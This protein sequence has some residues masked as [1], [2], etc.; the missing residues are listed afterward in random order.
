MENSLIKKE[1]K[2]NSLK[3]DLILALHDIGAV[4]FGSFKLKS[5]LTSPFYI[6]LRSVISYPKIM[7]MIVRLLSEA[8]EDL[9]FDLVTGIPYTAL[10][11][12]SVLSAKSNVPLIYQRK[13]PKVYGTGK[14]IE[15][16]YKDG[17]VCLVID[18]VMSTG[19]SKL[20]IANALLSA[21]IKIKD[22][23]IIVDRSYD[24]KAFMTK[25]G[26]NLVSIVTIH[27]IVETLYEKELMSVEHKEHVQ[28]FMGKDQTVQELSSISTIWDSSENLK[29]RALAILML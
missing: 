16:H 24:G 22:F 21:G 28:N 26:F 10:P 23:V 15:G 8:V 27:D 17:N 13:E 25:H 3:Q 5:G 6:D 20:E 14:S 4:K 1:K 18:D 12:A 9:Q 19:E 2:L 7:D 11:M 29:T